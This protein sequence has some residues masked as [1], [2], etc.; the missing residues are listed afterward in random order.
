[1]RGLRVALIDRGDFAGATSSRSSKLIHGG[2]RYLPHGEIALVRTA[3]AERERLRY[4]TAP[5]LVRAQRFLF[6]VYRDRGP[7]RLALG[8]GLWL[9][10]FF[11]RTPREERHQRLNRNAAIDAQP[12]LNSDNL[13]GGML[14]YDAVA[15][16]ARLT[17]EN[18]LDAAYHGGA[19]ANYVELTGFSRVGGRIA[20]ADVRDRIGGTG[21]ELRSRLF[22]NAAGPWVDDVRRLD[23]SDVAPLVR[24]TKG[25]HLVISRERI[26]VSE[27]L[28][29]S[30]AHGRIIFVIPHGDIVLIG[31]TDT[32][33]NS[34]RHRVAVE[35]E[36]VDYLLETVS[37]SLR[38]ARLNA[39]DVAANF[40]GLR[41]LIAARGAS[42]PSSVSRE[43]VISRS[44]SGLIS[45]AGGKLT[46]HRHIAERV[47]DLAAGVL[48][49]SNSRSPTIDTPLPG[50]R[51]ADLDINDGAEAL[52]A[53]P[54]EIRD[55][56]V[57]RYG[58][59]AVIP[60]RLASESPE[61]AR[62]LAPRCP[63][64][65]AEVIYTLGYEM[66]TSVSDFVVR[67]TA[68][69]WRH[70][71]AVRPAAAAASRLMAAM[72]GWDSAR[73]RGEAAN[74]EPKRSSDIGESRSS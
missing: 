9:Y 31:T 47:M 54:A 16:D 20:A 4:R 18:V 57:S 53:F 73:E 21:F 63:V 65:R 45:I 17:I 22:V 68:L 27:A 40:A 23:N 42:A 34:D 30:D 32:D 5:H 8:A 15:D 49:L 62:R 43:E 67:R 51:P 48:G 52:N 36:E 6:P 69:S 46:T 41:A 59:R 37:R 64:L 74:F 14:Y 25:V 39:A 28:V 10:D 55:A 11:A 19:V 12:L 70:P 71:S 44:P 56:M 2:L 50:A 66:A 61:L 29:L 1:M 60:A 33:F 7:G 24:L 72:L 13:L 38:C 58:T 35:A 3:L 26:P